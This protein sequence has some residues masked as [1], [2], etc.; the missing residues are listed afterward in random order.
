MKLGRPVIS[1]PVGDL[2]RLVEENGVGHVARETS[3]DAY[4]ETLT[5]GLQ[6]AP[7]Q[8]ATALLEMGKRFDLAESALRLVSGLALTSMAV[9]AID[10]AKFSV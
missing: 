10:A 5:R 3:A 2:T 9:K 8:H 7:W 1:M 6:D 4:A